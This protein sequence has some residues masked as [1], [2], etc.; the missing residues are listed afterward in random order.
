MI[1]VK[2]VMP[3][4]LIETSDKRTMIALRRVGRIPVILLSTITEEMEAAIDAEEE[5][6]GEISQEMY[7]TITR[8]DKDT[9][10]EALRIV[11]RV[12]KKNIKQRLLAKLEEVRS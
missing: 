3:E 4:R 2:W 10:S 8:G 5:L 1:Q 9:V 7:D 11:V 12:T 6:P